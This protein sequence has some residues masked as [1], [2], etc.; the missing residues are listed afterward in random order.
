MRD[1]L[2]EI[3]P[4]K[5]LCRRTPNHL[6]TPWR[7]LATVRTYLVLAIAVAHATPAP[8]APSSDPDVHQNTGA[9]RDQIPIDVPPGPGGLAPSLTLSFSGQQAD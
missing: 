8:A 2:D 4:S 5:W 9:A 1:P 7:I 6:Q 3:D